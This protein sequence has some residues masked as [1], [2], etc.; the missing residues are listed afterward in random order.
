MRRFWKDVSVVAAG[1]DWAIRLDGRVLN[2][3]MRSELILPNAA[4]ANAVRAEWDMVDKEIDPA[5]MPITGFANAAIDHVAADREGF[6]TAIS[7]YGENDALCYRAEAGTPLAVRQEEEWEPW[8][9]WAEQ[10]FDIRFVRVEGIIH[11][12]QS[13]AG[14]A[15]LR[16]A[17]S[18][19][20]NHELAALAKLAHLSGS[21]IAT[22]AI[23]EKAGGAET[24]WPEKLWG[25]CCLDELW[26]EELWGE[27]HWATKNRNDRAKDFMAA[28]RYLALLVSD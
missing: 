10:R 24:I 26:Q 18:V 12:P 14:L 20:S 5:L 23:A 13:L 27:D 9:T 19:H 4:V 2:T 11:Q 3:P 25:V 1:S 7:A 16:N 8:L 28:A 21:L 6:I 15:A 22:L 17:V